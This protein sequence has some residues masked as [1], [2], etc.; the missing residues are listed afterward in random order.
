MTRATPDASLFQADSPNRGS[1]GVNPPHATLPPDRRI[2]IG[3]ITDPDQV[4]A[5]ADWLRRGRGRG[6][7]SEAL[8]M[9]AVAGTA[10]ADDAMSGRTLPSC[11]FEF[12]NCLRLTIDLPWT[13]RGLQ[14]L[15]AAFREW[16]ALAAAWD[17]LAATLA[18]EIGPSWPDVDRRRTGFWP[19]TPKT[20]KRLR[21][22]LAQGGR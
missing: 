7:S 3:A 20:D 17:D 8:L 16:Q 6:L 10:P 22:A 21:Q 9:A 11:R 13:R 5:A 18:A 1:S 14:P 2:D 4:R 15:A 12:Y 19:D